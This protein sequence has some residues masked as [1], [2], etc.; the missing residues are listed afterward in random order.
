MQIKPLTANAQKDIK[1][2]FAVIANMDIQELEVINA[3]N[4]Q[5][6]ELTSFD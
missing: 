6:M 5:I 2:Y 4:A 1:A 3:K